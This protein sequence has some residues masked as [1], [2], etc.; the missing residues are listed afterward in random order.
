MTEQD[1]LLAWAV[2]AVAAMGCLL[3]GFRITRWMWRGLREPLRVVMAVL[4][5]SPTLVDPVRDF[6]AP[7]I[8]ITALDL[9][10]KTGGNLWRAIGDLAMFGMIGFALYLL[11]VV[12]RWPLL[13]RSRAKRQAA[14]AAREPTMREVLEQ[15]N[16][17]DGRVEPRL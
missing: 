13:R 6:Y 8:A 5:L 16:L 11:F 7:A 14:E 12:I 4:L 3:V 9:L 17:E 15:R 1:Y 2:Y 10:M